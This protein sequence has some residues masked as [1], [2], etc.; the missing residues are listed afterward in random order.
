MWKPVKGYEGFYCVSDDGEIK[1][2]ERTMHKG[3]CHRTWHEHILK[4]AIDAKGYLR[5]SLSK[6]GKTSTVKIH[7]VV[8]EA[9]LENPFDLPQVNH[10]DGNKQNNSV[11]NLEWISQSDNMKHACK[12]GLKLCSGENNSCSKLTVHDVVEIRNSD[13]TQKELAN[14][15]GVSKTTIARV[16]HHK[17]WKG[18]DADVKRSKALQT[19]KRC[20]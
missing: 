1:A 12:T 3:K 15:Y 6:N 18:G 16:I 5:T 10:I 14:L 20:S 17:S 2:L 13:L 7:R 19:S 8:A 4:T 11:S 9:F